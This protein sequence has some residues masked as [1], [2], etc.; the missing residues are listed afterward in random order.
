MDP[1]TKP[2]APL[3]TQPSIYYSQT[4]QS[5]LTE[6]KYEQA[7]QQALQGEDGGV[8]EEVDGEPL[9]PD[10]GDG[11]DSRWARDR[12]ASNMQFLPLFGAKQRYMN[13]HY[14]LSLFL[15]YL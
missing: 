9:G 5:L 12:E 1:S 6:W 10:G 7:E 8:D 4:I 13:N 14:I 15:L 11:G 3:T 2:S